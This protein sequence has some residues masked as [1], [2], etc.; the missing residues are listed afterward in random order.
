MKP[1]LFF[2]SLV[3]VTVQTL[4]KQEVVRQIPKTRD[5][6]LDDV[7]AMKAPTDDFEFS[8][9]QASNDAS[10]PRSKFT[11]DASDYRFEL[12]PLEGAT[13]STATGGES[14][15]PMELL[16]DGGLQYVQKFKLGEVPSTMVEAYD[17]SSSNIESFNA[18]FGLRC[19][20]TKNIQRFYM[21][22]DDNIGHLGYGEDEINKILYM[23]FMIGQDKDGVPGS[24]GE[25]AYF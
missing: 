7:G 13:C 2:S 17:P 6:L 14:T 20:K 9:L 4:A 24:G 11:E 15:W 18:A 3:A 5:D 23:C 25:C 8:P 22:H 12:F 21:F 10:S 19:T 16:R 1:V